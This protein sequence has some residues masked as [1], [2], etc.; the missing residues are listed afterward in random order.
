[1]IAVLA[2]ERRQVLLEDALRN[3]IMQIT[4]FATAKTDHIPPVKFELET[5]MIY[6]FEVRCGMVV[7]AN[8]TYLH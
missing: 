7:S 4:T 3:V 6:P 5:P 1:M 8:V 2:R